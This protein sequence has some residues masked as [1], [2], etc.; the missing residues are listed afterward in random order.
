M[1]SSWLY[2][3]APSSISTSA[4]LRECPHT[5]PEFDAMD[6]TASMT[7]RVLHPGHAGP[8]NRSLPT[9]A[10]LRW[11]SPWF[12]SARGA[13]TRGGVRVLTR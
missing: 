9:D 7:V 11:D 12:M 13:V 4:E 2:G 3:L 6:S 8:L 5:N 10:V 1:R